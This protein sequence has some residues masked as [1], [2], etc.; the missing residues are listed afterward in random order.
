M[1][2]QKQTTASCVRF[3]PFSRM[4]RLVYASECSGL[5]ANGGSIGRF[6]FDQLALRPQEDAEIVVRIGMIRIER[7]RVLTRGDRLVQLESI[8]QDDPQIAVPVRPIGLELE[9]SLDQRDG[10]LAPPLLMGEHSRVVHRVGIVGRHLEDPAVD[11][12]RRHPLV[13]LL[14]PDRDRYRFVQAD[15]R[16]PLSATAP[17]CFNRARA[18]L[19]VS[20]AYP[21]LLPLMSYLK[22]IP[23]SSD[24]SAFCGLY[25]RSTLAN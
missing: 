7:N 6:R 21:S 18:R 5:D 13:A 17:Y 20:P 14:Q 1:T 11:V 22:W 3:W 12:A 25:S 19:E 23:A 24:P 2:L 4:P 10:L 15:E 8:P 9:A 16:G